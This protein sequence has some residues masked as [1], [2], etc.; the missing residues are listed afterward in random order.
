M[1]KLFRKPTHANCV[2]AT[3]AKN[4]V[5]YGAVRLLPDPIVVPNLY[6]DP[7]VR[8]T[9]AVNIVHCL[10][11]NSRS[12]ARKFRS[13]ILRRSSTRIQVNATRYNI[14]PEVD[15]FATHFF[16]LAKRFAVA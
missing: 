11:F 14:I 8:V 5:Q 2:V 4:S 7:A 12:S 13:Q 9:L 3:S 10:L 15:Y 1:V 16:V 6:R